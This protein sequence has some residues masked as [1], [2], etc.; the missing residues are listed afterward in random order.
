MAHE[1]GK[2]SAT[3][4]PVAPAANG[5]DAP[6]PADGAAAAP[7]S[8]SLLPRGVH[9][10]WRLG[11]RL[12]AEGQRLDEVAR[13]LRV[14]R[15]KVERNLLRSQRFRYMIEQERL[16]RHEADAIRFSSLRS[17]LIDQLGARIRSGDQRILLWAANALGPGDAW[18]PYEIIERMNNSRHCHSV[19][20]PE[21]DP[22]NEAGGDV[23]DT[24]H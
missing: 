2:A 11:A 24:A 3:P 16:T 20:K 7:A 22:M 14:T 10:D 15:R 1:T 9:A 6:Q 4:G 21:D 8:S 23:P 13:A 19:Q 18:P 12:I 5:P 17:D